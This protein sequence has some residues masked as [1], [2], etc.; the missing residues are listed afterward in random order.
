MR[1]PPLLQSVLLAF[2]VLTL[3]LPVF[4]PDSGQVLAA[5]EKIDPSLRR[6]IA[7]EPGSRIPVIVEMAQAQRASQSRAN[8]AR[9]G[10]ALRLLSSLGPDGK[11]VGGLPLIGGAA[12]VASAKGIEALSRNPRVAFVHL[13]ATVQARVEGSVAPS[14]GQLAAPYPFVTRAHKVWQDGTTGKGIG[15][16]VLDS[17]IAPHEDL[18]S[19]TNRLVASVNFA[20]DLGGMPDA[21]GHGTHV[22][23]VIA[24]NSTGADLSGQQMQFLSSGSPE[25]ADYVGMAPGANLIDVRVLN[26]QGSGRISSV[27]AG[28]QWVLDNRVRYNIRVVNLS[29]GGPIGASYRQDPL[30]AAMEVA[31][32]SGIVVVAAAGNDGPNRDTVHTPGVD[33]YVITVGATDSRGTVA[34]QDDVWGSFSS[35]GIPLEST[36]KPDLVAPGRQIV[37][38]RV[39]GSYLDRLYPERVVTGRTGDKYFRL[40]GTSM[41]TAVVSGVVALMLERQPGLKPDQVKAILSKATQNYGQTSSTP[42]PDPVAHGA[43]LVNAS[44]ATGG[45][46]GTPANRGLRPSDGFA[47][48][49]Y[50]LIHGQPLTW[51]DPNYAGISWDNLAWDNL[52]WDNLAWDNLAWDNL[53]WDN[54]AWDNLAWDNLAWDNLAWDNLAWDNLVWDSHALD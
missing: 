14:T 34:V 45:S 33:P 6:A 47:R 26:S 5:S 51:K 32:K 38:L 16:A 36:P 46:T 52:A 7:A 49:V 8:E 15:I 17:G 24:G 1:I 12:G 27:V 9:A 43:G 25:V 13:D 3:L 44:T 30:S 19:P 18:V 54:L 35:W 48:T 31:W 20:G 40:T 22:A 53:A 39:P 23:G 42:L 4:T 29:L 28:I 21:G 11:Q 50:P 37:S 10:E 41:S 2:L